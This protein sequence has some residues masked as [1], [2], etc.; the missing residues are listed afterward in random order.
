MRFP[1]LRRNP[2]RPLASRR[3]DEVWH[4][5][6]RHSQQWHHAHCARGQ[7]GSRRHRLGLGCSGTQK[8]GRLP[9]AAAASQARILLQLEELALSM[10]HRMA[11]SGVPLAAAHPYFMPVRAGLPRWPM[12]WHT[13]L[14]PRISPSTIDCYKFSQRKRSPDQS[15]MRLLPHRSLSFLPG[16]L[17]TDCDACEMPLAQVVASARRRL[18]HER[19]GPRKDAD[20]DV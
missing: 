5:W 17:P 11:V 2:I 18:C 1:L 12:R 7:L 13:T 3:R 14:V 15:C 6:Q 20:Q 9:R 8:V 10:H 16:C 4:R 19:L